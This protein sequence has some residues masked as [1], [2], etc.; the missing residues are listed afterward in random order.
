MLRIGLI[1]SMLLAVFICAAGCSTLETD[2]P[3]NR[4]LGKLNNFYVIQQEGSD[5][6]GAID[7]A[8]LFMKRNAVSGS[9]DKIPMNVDAIITFEGNWYWDMSMYL[10]RL[11]IQLHD[12]QTRTI[13]A[14]GICYHPSLERES[15]QDMAYEIF[16]KLFNEKDARHHRPVKPWRGGAVN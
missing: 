2:N 11:K 10:L 1:L 14:E 5:L 8:L 4:D 6:D 13:I 15:P 9:S 12:P 16:L 3:T 7:N